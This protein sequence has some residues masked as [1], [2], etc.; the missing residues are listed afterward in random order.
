MKDTYRVNEDGETLSAR[1]VKGDEGKTIEIMY[2]KRNGDYQ[3]G[4][5]KGGVEQSTRAVFADE[6]QPMQNSDGNSFLQM[7]I[8]AYDKLGPKLREQLPAEWCSILGSWL[9]KSG[10][11][12]AIDSMK[13][14]V[15]EDGA[16]ILENLPKIIFGL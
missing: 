13:K 10:Y 14:E 4:L 16:Q 2:T 6:S 11:R 7:Y 5:Y 1:L 8:A 12:K 9:K 3:V 15:G